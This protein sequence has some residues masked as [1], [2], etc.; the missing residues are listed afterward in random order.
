MTGDVKMSAEK[1]LTIW[2]L[3]DN[4]E[5]TENNNE[6][7]SEVK[8]KM[9][10]LIK[11][12]K[13][14]GLE[15]LRMKSENIDLLQTFVS[16]C[17]IHFTTSLYWRY[18]ACNVVISEIF[19]ASDEA[20]CILLIENNA[21]D[22]A[23]MFQEQKK[24]SRKDARPKYTK[25]ECSDK[26]FKGWDRRGI[27]RFN[28]IVT[29]IQKYREFTESKDMEMTLKSKYIELSGKENEGQDDSDYDDC[30]LD[31][32]NGYDGFAGVA[33]TNS[34]PI[35]DTT[36]DDCILGATNITRV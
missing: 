3:P 24:V 9:M 35:E 34:V 12:A 7:V 25:V 21:E 16:Y 18:N 33:D 36:T 17:L 8:S 28:C 5:T 27:Y 2:N 31:E 11:L 23:K 19:T 10:K 1:R 4:E 32:L 14:G 20:L 26:K 22:Y 29:E 13:D 6:N 30:D 15:K